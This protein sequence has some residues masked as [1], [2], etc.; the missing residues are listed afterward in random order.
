MIGEIPTRLY[1]PPA[2]TGLLLLGHGGGHSKDGLRFVGLARRYA[3]QTGLAVVCID[4][5][6][7][8]ERRPSGAT[9]EL[10]REWH[11]A[12]IDQMVQDWGTTVGA[13]SSIGPPVAYVGFSMGAI[14]GLP[15]VAALPT[16]VRAVFVVG[17]IP[18]GDWIDDAPLRPLL[19]HAAAE[20]GHV[21]VLMLNK[22]ADDQFPVEDVQALYDSMRARSKQLIFW[23]GRHDDWPDAM[24]DESVEFVNR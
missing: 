17:G 5:V 10:P 15:T 7:H 1:E 3:E 21:D 11:S 24:I 4:A 6:D 23:P 20:L 16:V 13:L 8:G 9:A 14:F 18:G 12:A 2:A 22:T 19:E